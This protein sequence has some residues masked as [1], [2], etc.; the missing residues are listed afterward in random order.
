MQIHGPGTAD[1]IRLAV[2]STAG[3]F[4]SIRY[5]HVIMLTV[6]DSMRFDS[7]L[8]GRSDNRLDDRPDDRRDDHLNGRRDERL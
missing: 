4:D 6:A 1:S 5:G 2:S 3:R 7:S 8:D